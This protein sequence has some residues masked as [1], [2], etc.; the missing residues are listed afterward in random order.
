MQ[1]RFLHSGIVIEVLPFSFLLI[2]LTPPFVSGLRLNGRR[3]SKLS[4]RFPAECETKAAIAKCRVHQIR[5]RSNFHV[6][7]ARIVVQIFTGLGT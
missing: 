7:N 6:G 1:T 4:Y 5:G 3:H 2:E